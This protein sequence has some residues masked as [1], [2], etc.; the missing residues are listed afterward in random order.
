MW[1]TRGVYTTCEGVQGGSAIILRNR[2]AR[3]LR[4][5]KNAPFLLS[6][7]VVSV[8]AS[9]FYARPTQAEFL[10]TV[11]TCVI[12]IGNCAPPPTDGTDPS[13]TQPPS[14]T[15]TEETG[16]GE[17]TPPDPTVSD[18]TVAPTVF[19]DANPR[20][21]GGTSETVTITGTVSDDN[22]SSY[23]VAVNNVIAQQGSDL[24]EKNVTINIPWSVSTPQRIPSDTYVITLDATDKAGNPAHTEIT[25]VVDN[26]PPTE[27]VTGGNVIIQG[28]SITPNVTA[29]DIHGPIEYR[30][31]EDSDDPS[32][33]DF[34]ASAQEPTFTPRAEGSYLFYVQVIDGLGNVANDTF[35]FDY[36][37]EL[38]TLPLPVTSDPSDELTVGS[39]VTPD[40][41]PVSA[42]PTARS[43]RDEVPFSDDGGVLGNTISASGLSPSTTQGAVVS[44]TTGGWSIFGILWYW[45]LVVIGVIITAWFFIKKYVFSSLAK[46]S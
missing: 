10:N 19:I 12:N 42:D 9:G 43:S 25:V 26:T 14:E 3:F 30:W 28:G 41:T 24:N 38:A 22:L 34:D 35:T 2:H 29:D 4:G 37:R 21:A 20:L 31:S 33:L 18:D 11:L 46:D 27:S 8:L 23:S 39:A 44:P 36:V 16:P 5:A 17:E 32:I 6:V 40:I 7:A 15:P 45:W 1:Y 13:V